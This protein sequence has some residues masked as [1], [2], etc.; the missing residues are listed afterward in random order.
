MSLLCFVISLLAFFPSS[1]F[2]YVNPHVP[3]SRFSPIQTTSS[4]PFASFH[5]F[6]SPERSILLPASTHTFTSIYP[7]SLFQLVFPLY[8]FLSLVLSFWLSEDLMAER[9]EGGTKCFLLSIN[10]VL[11]AC[12]AR[13]LPGSGRKRQ[14]LP[15]EIYP[16]LHLFCLKRSHA[17]FHTMLN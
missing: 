5:L 9:C 6:S 17:I 16:L 2:L 8:F 11:Y 12:V 1:F 4:S 13:S 14:A 15:A 10:T 3:H 7:L